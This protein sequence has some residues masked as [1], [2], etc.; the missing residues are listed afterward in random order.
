MLKGRKQWISNATVCDLM[1][2]T[3]RKVNADGTSSLARVLVDPVES[4]FEAREVRMHGLR[5]APLG[6]TPR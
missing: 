2:V 5:Q 3:C 1:N 4:P 6:G